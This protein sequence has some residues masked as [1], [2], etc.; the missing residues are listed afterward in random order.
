[1]DRY[2]YELRCTKIE[3]TKLKKKK[4]MRHFIG[5]RRRN[6]EEEEKGKEPF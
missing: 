2:E 1:M 5:L 4:K 6:K 3:R